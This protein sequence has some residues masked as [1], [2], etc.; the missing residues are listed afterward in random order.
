MDQENKPP[1]LFSFYFG[2][3]AASAQRGASRRL[4]KWSRAFEQWIGESRRNTRVDTVKHA[5]LAWRRLVRQCDKMPWEIKQEDIQQ[6]AAWMNQE[7][8]ALSTMNASIRFFASFYRWCAAHHVDSA[9]GPGF[10]PATGAVKTKLKRYDAVSMWSRNELD[11]FLRLLARDGSPLGKRDYAFYLA[12]LNLGVPL[13]TLQHLE[14]EQI[15]LDELEAWVRWRQAGSPV[16]LPD[17]VWQAVID[18][19]QVS[20]RLGGMQAGKYI[21][22]PQV[23]PVVEGSGGI[24]QDWLEEQPLS[25]S[26][27][28]SSLKLYGGQLGISDLK[29]TLMSLRRTSIRL[30]MDQGESLE[31][32]Q[33]FMDTAEKIKSTKYRLGKLPELPADTALDGQLHV[34]DPQLPV[35][36]TRRLQGSEGTTH[37][38]FALRQDKQAI[39]DVI[40]EDIHGMDQET[41]CLRVLLRGLL[42]R[43]GDEAR[44]VEL[45]SRAA[46][47]LGSLVSVGET[48]KKEVKN[49][50]VEDALRQLDEIELFVG[51]S[52]VSQRI[53]ANALGLSPE[54]LQA[55]SGLTEEIATLR[56]LLRNVYRRAIQVIETREYLHLVDLY[57]LGCVRLARLHRVGGCD[58]NGRLERYLKDGIDEAIREVHFE[59]TSG[60]ER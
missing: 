40:T 31:G 37:G 4:K 20:G 25:R 12:R 36:Q 38:F 3:S 10:N 18:Y 60:S 54:S 13:K 15:E 24:A 22:S 33:V 43:E 29:L 14:W 19:L 48:I 52:P 32:M 30:R 17:Q 42:E 57:S 46:H 1:L 35:R 9:C 47:R 45:Y 8:F 34:F 21:F 44:L 41:A 26:A 58:E 56:L 7:G 27:I 5:L 16:K 50:W 59:L 55:A 39:K 6:H 23:P 53:R 51:R 2:D 11:A 28:L 49:P